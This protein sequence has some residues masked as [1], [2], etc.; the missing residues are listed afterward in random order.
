LRYVFRLRRRKVP[1]WIGDGE[2]I[3][4]QTLSRGQFGD[5]IQ[6]VTPLGKYRTCWCPSALEYVQNPSN[7]DVAEE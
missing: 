5:S 1:V 2:H 4:I 3:P 7:C 6:L